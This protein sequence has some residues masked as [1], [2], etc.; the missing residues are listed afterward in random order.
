MPYKSH[1][2][3]CVYRIRHIPTDVTIYIGKTNNPKKRWNNHRNGKKDP[4]L[5]DYMASHGGVNDYELVPLLWV[6]SEAVAYRK[7]REIIGA[8]SGYGTLLNR[9][10][11]GVGG[12]E[13]QTSEVHK[14]RWAKLTKE[15]RKE[16]L[17][18]LHESRRGVPLDPSHKTAVSKA[19][20]QYHSEHPEAA[21]RTGARRKGQRHTN[22]AKIKMGEARKKLSDEQVRT[23]RAMHE[24]G[25]SMKKIGTALGV[26]IKSVFNA[27][28]GNGVY[29]SHRDFGRL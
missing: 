9:D 17:R 16:R 1:K 13:G 22:A 14:R 6:P 24:A 29:G 27:I 28:H 20:L 5:L 11:G 25:I 26:S 18:P 19:M 3:F 12:Q 8:Y 7:E 10:L 4:L 21:L 15:Q 23:V 2:D